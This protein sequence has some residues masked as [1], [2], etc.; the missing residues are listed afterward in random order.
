MTGRPDT[1]V[2]EG[3]GPR[4]EHGGEQD[5]LVVRRSA[6]PNEEETFLA[7]HETHRGT[8][9]VKAIEWLGFEGDPGTAVGLRVM[10]ADGA[11]DIVVHTLDE[12]PKFPEHRVAGRDVRVRGRFA[13][14]RMR[15]GAVEWMYL[16]QGSELG[17]GEASLSAE[18][19]E[20]SHRGSV[21][22]VER[23]ESGDAENAF[24]VDRS[25]PSDGSLS[26]KTLLVKWGNGW[27]WAY[28]IERV[29][30]SRI[31]TADE[32]GFELR[33]GTVSSQYFPIEEFLGLESFPGP[34]SFLIAGSALR[35][36]RGHLLDTK[37]AG[38]PPSPS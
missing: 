7:V 29:E 10:L 34:V 3:T 12:G 17:V 13:H 36:R 24:V 11:E 25:L 1:T 27:V 19:G 2:F 4:Y 20:Y 28:R 9:S 32:P 14:I 5:H 8:G 6:D 33:G 31:V 16:V 35:D 30:G 15:G 21:N 26:G 18:P 37:G 22:R 23:R 38:S